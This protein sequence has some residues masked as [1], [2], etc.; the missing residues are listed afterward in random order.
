M[1]TKKRSLSARLQHP[2]ANPLASFSKKNKKNICSLSTFDISTG[3]S[4]PITKT[5]NKKSNTKQKTSQMFSLSSRKQKTTN[6]SLNPSK[7]IKKQGTNS[8]LCQKL[9]NYVDQPDFDIHIDEAIIKKS[10]RN[11][12]QKS[13]DLKLKQKTKKQKK[14]YEQ[15]KRQ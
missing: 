9:H 10:G 12:H 2:L 6:T 5:S 15:N 1:K 8:I 3:I 4:I 11:H 7:T 13:I 14:K